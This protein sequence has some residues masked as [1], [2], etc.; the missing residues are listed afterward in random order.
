MT[1]AL[2]SLQDLGHL[3][4]DTLI[5]TRSPAEYAEDHIPGAIN[6]P[7]LSNE[8]RARVGTIYTQE[9]PFLARK[10]GGALVARNIAAHLDGPLADHD[11]A[12]QPLIYCWRGGQRSGAFTLWL[13]EVG[14]RAEKLAGG[15][16]AYRR[17]I[18]AQLYD[19]TV[20]HRILLLDGN[21]G[22]AKTELLQRVAR[23]GGQV[24]DLE[25]LANHRGSVLGLRPGG[26]PSQKM[27]E[28]RISAALAGMDPE[29]PVLVE[30]ESSKVGDLLVP[31]ALWLAMRAAP[32]V[33]LH[34]TPQDRVRYLCRAYADLFA[35]L[36][37][38]KERLA[39]LTPMQGRARIAEWHGWAEAGD[40][41]RLVADLID[42]HYDARYANKRDA[43]REGA[44]PLSVSLDD[45]GLD[46]A[47]AAL[48][49]HMA[50][51]A[52]LRS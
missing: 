38:F 19:T 27:F 20:P 1:F 7:V 6:L 46:R 47:A 21:T 33:Q 45:A 24:L 15:Y 34:A 39:L 4:F 23:L 13:R 35:D 48:V 9:S 40:F 11:G 28:T 42:R 10:I 37:L 3:P 2:P 52:P 22:T 29:Q 14:W 12:W 50:G 43:G 30:A 32:R 31:P 36:P 41:P 49:S 16:R 5:D 25:G 26:Q 17:A 18:V 51:D 8:E 44:T